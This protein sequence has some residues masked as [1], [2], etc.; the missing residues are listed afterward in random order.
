MSDIDDHLFDNDDNK[1]ATIIFQGVAE[2]GDQ[3]EPCPFDLMN[4]PLLIEAKDPLPQSNIL[5]CLFLIQ[6]QE[7][8]IGHIWEQMKVQTV[9][10]FTLTRAFKKKDTVTAIALLQCC[11][12]LWFT[13]DLC[14]NNEDKM[15]I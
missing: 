7:Y 15:L 6:E 9:N 10:L 1:M 5:E 8:S 11:S 3:N 2:Q 12:I 14:Y 13:N 4:V